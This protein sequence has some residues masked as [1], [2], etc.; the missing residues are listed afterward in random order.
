MSTVPQQEGNP[1]QTL[2]IGMAGPVSTGE[3]ADLL[4]LSGDVMNL[5]SGLGG[6]MVN[7]LI[8]EL[9]SRGHQLTV[10]T[11]DPSVSET[12]I[13]EGERLKVLYGPFRQKRAR[14]FFRLERTWLRT[15]MRIEAPDLVH[16]HWAYEYAL[17]ARRSG[18]PY[19]ISMRDAPLKV[20]KFNL[21]PYR[22]VRTL[23]AYRAILGAK[24]VVANSP[25]I[26]EHLKRWMFYR[27]PV[28]IVPNGT[29]ESLFSD[30]PRKTRE[31]PTAVIA[32]ILSGWGSLKNGEAAI[33]SLALLHQRGEKSRLIMFGEDYDNNGPAYR[34]ACQLGVEQHIEFPGR[35]PFT[36]LMKRLR[37]EVD[38]V[39]HP[40]L[41]ESFGNVL[42]EAMAKCIP[43]V[44]GE[45]S[46]AVPWVLGGGR[47]GLLV[48]VSNPEAIAEALEQLLTS[49]KK[50]ESLATAGHSWAK[51]RFHITQIARSYEAIYENVLGRSR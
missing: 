49:R 11:L 3:I 6:T 15:A 26:A 13:A 19:L 7:H 44:G 22:I 14:D 10:F 35:L 2:H 30:C 16:A 21:A 4:S 36:D 34:L 45:N 32:T 47:G 37:E 29:P 18:L 5:P 50:R 39:L 41:E 24:K 27:K 40:A 1:E 38:I 51:S 42:V 17:A 31:K 28:E 8:R 20:L 33:R 12:V 9:H 46:G 43:V 25:Y 23:M 48:D